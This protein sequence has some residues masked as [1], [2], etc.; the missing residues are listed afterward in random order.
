[1][2]APQLVWYRWLHSLPVGLVPK[3]A[4]QLAVMPPSTVTL[5]FG[6]T[7]AGKSVRGEA[8]W[9][10]WQ[11]RYFRRM[12]KEALS[13]VGYATFFWAP[14]Q[15]FN[16]SRVPLQFRPL[17]LNCMMVVWTTYLSI[18]GFKRL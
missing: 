2:G 8:P 17:F 16:F 12:E 3:L 18:V 4:I 13:T 14:V 15:A 10:T 9:G 6:Y 1:M 5:F 7:E 11:S